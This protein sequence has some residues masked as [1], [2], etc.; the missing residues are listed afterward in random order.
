MAKRVQLK[1]KARAGSGRGAAKRLRAEGVVPAVI[2]GACTK[3]LNVAVVAEELEKVLQEATSENVLVDLQ[4][5]EGGTTKNRLALIQEVQHHPYEDVVLH[6][7]FHEV[8]ATEKLR[9]RVPVRPVGEPAGVKTGGGV[10]EYVMRDLHV[11]CLPQDLPEIIEVNVEKLEISQSIHVG[12]IAPPAG[13]AL[14]D[15]KGQTVFLVVA[16]ITEEELAAMTEA[17]AAPSAEPEVITAKTEEGEEVAVAEGEAKP[18]AEAG[19][20]EAKAPAAGA[21]GKA[22]A[23]G[24]A[25]KAPAAGAGGK[26]PAAGAAGKSPS[27]AAG[28]G[29]AKPAGKRAAK[30]E[31]KK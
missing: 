28:K 7:D 10:L 23:A 31:A 14:L 24:A 21:A 26:A 5:D 4:V 6:I 18:K 19:K 17:A 3:P 13:V 2:Y 29:E 22:P 27:A 20:A 12:D 8:L 11:E 9:A 30:P 1:A 25:G 15:S 16:P